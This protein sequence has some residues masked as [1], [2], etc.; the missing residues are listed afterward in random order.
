MVVVVAS[1]GVA[2]VGVAGDFEELENA[3]HDGPDP[4]DYCQ[5]YLD[6]RWCSDGY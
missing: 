1:A 3:E 2:V 5:E 4:D 6:A